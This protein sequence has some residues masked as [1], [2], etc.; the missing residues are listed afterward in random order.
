MKTIS[1]LSICLISFSML[2]SACNRHAEESSEGAKESMGNHANTPAEKPG[3][4]YPGSAG[5][6]T[7]N[8]KTENTLKDSQTK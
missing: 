8:T 4:E 5:P 1:Y 2:N 7:V 6:D 3:T